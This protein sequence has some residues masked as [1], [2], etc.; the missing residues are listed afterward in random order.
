[1]SRDENL[2]A[3]K[4]AIAAVDSLGH[5]SNNR[6]EKNG[7]DQGDADTIE[8]AAFGI[9]STTSMAMLDALGN[10]REEPRFVA[11]VAAPCAVAQQLSFANCEGRA[12]LALVHC[13]Q[14]STARPLEL[15][16]SLEGDHVFLVIGRKSGKI[17][18]VSSWNDDAVVCDPWAGSCYP[19]AELPMRVTQEPLKAVTEGSTRFS[20]CFEHTE[21]AWPPRGMNPVMANQHITAVTKRW[22]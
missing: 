11:Q 13:G 18:D 2:A 21:P 14:K 12:A 3:G 1:M 4:A 10:P 17:M 22:S 16:S 20:Q 19:A 8:Q 6:G 15:F 9:Y 5:S 7:L